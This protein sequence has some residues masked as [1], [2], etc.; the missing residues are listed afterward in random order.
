MRIA[1]AQVWSDRTAPVLSAGKSAL[2][3]VEAADDEDEDTGA[4]E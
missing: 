2:F 3:W 1:V 4:T